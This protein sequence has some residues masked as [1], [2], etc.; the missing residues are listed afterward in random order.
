MVVRA[1]VLPL[2]LLGGC[3]WVHSPTRDPKPST[4]LPESYEQ[5]K[6][7]ESRWK[8]LQGGKGKTP[9]WE[10]FSDHH[11]DR[12]IRTALKGSPRLGAAWA[13]VREAEALAAQ[14]GAP[15]WPQVSAQA[16]VGRQRVRFGNFGA[17]EFDTYALSVPVSYELDL[18]GRLDAQAKAGAMDALAADEEA[19]AT[20]MTLSAE[21]ADAWYQLL[22]GRR[23][24]RVL[25]DQ[26]NTQKR[27]LSLMRL[28]FDRGLANA[29]DLQ[30]QQLEVAAVAS[31]VP[32]A[33]AS[34]EV[35]RY[36]LAVLVGQVPQG[37][38]APE[39]ERF[40]PL[41]ALPALGIPADLLHLR[42]DVR[43][44]MRRAE[45]ADWR[46]GQAIAARFPSFTLSA[47][48]GYNAVELAELFEELIWSVVGQL[49]QVVFDGGARGAEVDRFRATL[50]ARLHEYTDVVLQ[51]LGEVESALV[52][53]AKQREELA[54][55]EQQRDLALQTFETAR[56]RYGQGLSELLPVLTAMQ[57]KQRAELAHVNGQRQLLSFRVQLHRA[58]GGG[59]LTALR[60]PAAR[61]PS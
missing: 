9:W 10:G 41:P 43:A 18:F 51:A 30:Q 12:L 6:G 39:G 29:L 44:A 46:V 23:Q 22:Q 54:A 61:G 53:E 3:L 36:R 37:F 55:L 45:A 5:G 42:P 58:L 15:R 17:Q 33:E 38:S 14:A 56:A 27:F 16:S 28:R 20:A 19:R 35:A 24:S 13:R 26:L 34:V 7:T 60:E 11:L 25:H 57:S 32:D 52:Q 4:A 40:P 2:W 47:S 48:I 1:S 21:V 49:T 8:A 50:Q 31:Q 59:W